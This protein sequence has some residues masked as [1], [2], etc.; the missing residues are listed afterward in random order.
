MT[1]EEIYK[2]IRAIADGY[3]SYSDQMMAI[4]KWIE[5]ELNKPQ[6][7][8]SKRIPVSE[9]MPEGYIAV[10]CCNANAQDCPPCIGVLDPE[11]G[12]FFFLEIETYS[13]LITH[14]QPLPAPPKP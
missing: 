5:S 1:T 7:D 12:K 14:W 4:T 8:K 3:H 6:E 9:R 2:R 11:K 13:N 10:L